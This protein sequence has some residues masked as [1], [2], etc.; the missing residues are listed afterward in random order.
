VD[1]PFD[2]ER[3]K[4]LRQYALKNNI[5]SKEIIQIA[6]IFLKG[7]NCTEDHIKEQLD[8]CNKFFKN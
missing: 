6:D 4:E 3:A 8:K 2:L 5:S 7:R 1:R